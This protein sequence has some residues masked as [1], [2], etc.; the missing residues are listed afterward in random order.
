MQFVLAHWPFL[1]KEFEW[2]QTVWLF[3]KM[4][5]LPFLRNTVNMI[6]SVSK[7]V[8]VSESSTVITNM[9]VNE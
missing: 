2:V 6:M 8:N 4:S 5:N 7:N 1:P 9:K 3:T